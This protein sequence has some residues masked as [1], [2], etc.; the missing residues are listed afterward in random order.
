MNDVKER[1]RKLAKNPLTDCVENDA[2]RYIEHLESRVE[3]LEALVKLNPNSVEFMDALDQGFM[4]ALEDTANDLEKYAERSRK[5]V[6]DYRKATRN[7]PIG[8]AQEGR[9]DV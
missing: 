7:M 8:K 1:L 3:T 6:A 5:R 2:L 4:A 9:T